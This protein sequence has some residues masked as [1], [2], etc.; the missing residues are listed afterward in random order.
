MDTLP[1]FPLPGLV[2]LPH[3]LLPLH[4]FEPRYRV[5]VAEALEHNSVFGIPRIL[6][7]PA[8]RAG[9]PPFHSIFGVG[10]IVRHQP[11]ADGRS[12]IVVLGVGRARLDQELSS[13]APYRTGACTLLE[14]TGVPS[15]TTPGITRTLS[16][17]L[18]VALQVVSGRAEVAQELKRLASP[19]RDPAEAVNLLAHLCLRDPD[20]RQAYLELDT[21]HERADHLLALLTSILYAQ[22]ER[23]ES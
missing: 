2:F 18:L 15:T 22:R 7:T 21:V 17:I 12:H 8:T 1:L 14:D 9:N 6:D 10:R 23:P 11:L 4:I 13:D 5:M 19:E 16:Q 20:A 3:T